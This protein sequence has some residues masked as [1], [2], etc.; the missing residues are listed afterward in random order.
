MIAENATGGRRRRVARWTAA[1]V[2]AA[3]VFAACSSESD[4]DEVSGTT[5]GSDEPRDETAADEPAG[6]EVLGAPNPATDAPVTVGFVTAEGGTAANLPETRESAEAAV[7]YANEYL[8][9]I[10]GHEIELLTCEDRSDGA[11]ATACANRF[12]EEDVVAVVAGQ[13]A[14]EGLYMPALEAAGIPW[15]ISS[16]TGGAALNSPVSF[17]ISGGFIGGMGAMAALAQEEGMD[18]V[19]FFGID[20]PAFTAAFDAL[21]VPT[22]EQAGVTA[23]IVPIPPGTPD[24]TPQVTAGLS[25][26]ADMVVLVAEQTLCKALLPAV[27]SLAPDVTLVT[28]DLCADPDV[29]ETVGAATLEGALVYNAA[30]SLGDDDGGQL[31]RAVMEQYAPDTAPQG[32]TGAGFIATLALVGAVNQ[33]SPTGDLTAAVVLDAMET[34]V[35]VPIPGWPDGTFT[36]DHT[37]FAGAPALCSTAALFATVAEG[38]LTGHEAHDGGDFLPG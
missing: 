1:G 20:V 19:V 6:D 28:G 27:H 15:I 34:A 33:V 14:D 23:D 16:P 11:S 29:I 4:S 18:R 10:A 36:C 32:K 3:L 7:A 17:G 5:V 9:G 26:G 12:V 8:G 21:G 37:A 25:D 38:A 13:V 24:A 30:A 2:V 35:D 22:F 31:F